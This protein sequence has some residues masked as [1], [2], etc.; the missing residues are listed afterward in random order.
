MSHY[1]YLVHSEL[2]H[3]GIKGMKWGVRKA[4]D[5]WQKHWRKKAS[6]WTKTYDFQRDAIK[7]KGKLKSEYE[8]FK[9]D[10]AA[11]GTNRLR[12]KDYW[13]K[14]NQYLRDINSA[15]RDIREMGNYFTTSG[16]KVN[17]INAGPRK[18]KA[19]H[20]LHGVQGVAGN[21]VTAAAIIGAGKAINNANKQRQIRK[22]EKQYNLK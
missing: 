8:L 7:R 10:N 5:A 9:A 18:R 3:H 12:N 4:K 11:R 2:A 21:A 15:D 22:A 13:K 16:Q 20:Y 19:L 17:Y 1:G 14:S 6:Q